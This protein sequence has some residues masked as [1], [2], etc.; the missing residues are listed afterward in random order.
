MKIQRV[1]WRNHATGIFKPGVSDSCLPLPFIRRTWYKVP[2]TVWLAR[3][4]A[5]AA[6][7]L[8]CSS[9]AVGCALAGRER[10]IDCQDS[11]LTPM[12]QTVP[13]KTSSS[14]R[15]ECASTPFGYFRWKFRVASIY[16]AIFAS[17]V[18]EFVQHMILKIYIYIKINIYKI[19]YIIKIL[20]YIYYNY[21]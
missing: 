11:F 20:Y 8:C 9:T 19:L 21:I 18:Q 7:V 12:W 1:P 16:V 14:L 3:S 15:D 5:T 2:R 6:S 4:I 17:Q 13:L 10:N